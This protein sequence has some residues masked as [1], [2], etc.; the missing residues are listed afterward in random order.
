LLTGSAGIKPVAGVRIVSM[1]EF[2]GT[3][4]TSLPGPME[5]GI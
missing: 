2:T 3:L 1:A 5:N 4:I